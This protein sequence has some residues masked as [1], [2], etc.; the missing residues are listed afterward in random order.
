M[1]SCIPGENGLG[2]QHLEE[3]TQT[4]LER[5]FARGAA[6]MGF[7]ATKFGQQ[8]HFSPVEGDP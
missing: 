6:L 7:P 5:D 1:V 8:L 2:G 3:A 4:A